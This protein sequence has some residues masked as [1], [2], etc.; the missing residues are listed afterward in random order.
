M[1]KTI[2][3]VFARG[4]SKGLP[5]KNIKPL[6]GKP[7]IQYSIERALASELI[8]DVYVSTDDSKIAEVALK[9]GANIIE[10]PK[11][12]ATDASPEWLSWQQ[13]TNWVTQNKG[14]FDIFV[15]L[16]ATSPLTNKEDVN[17]AISQL[18]RSNADI[19]LS[20]TP[21]NHHPN[22]NMV[23]LDNNNYARLMLTSENKVT[24][25]QDT[26]RAYNITTCVYAATVD[27]IFKATG[28]FDGTVT[29]IEIPR[30][31]SVDIDDI[32]DFKFAELLKK[33]QE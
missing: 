32:I 9:C 7:L 27:F 23:T 3:F 15:S 13:A 18:K 24:R 14:P 5:G 25:R 12:L 2:A 21:S 6:C 30:Q 8:D 29:A 10:R 1:S 31:R 22:F 4:G 20:V 33:E 26:S 11:E 16:P 17:A 19:C 28:I